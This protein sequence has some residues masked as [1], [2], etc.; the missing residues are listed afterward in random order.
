[1]LARPSKK[2]EITISRVT[3]LPQSLM[4]DCYYVIAQSLSVAAD[5]F[6][7]RAQREVNH[8]NHI[9]FVAATPIMVVGVIKGMVFNMPDATYAKIDCFGVDKRYRKRGIGK[10]LLDAYEKYV[11][12][13]RGASCVGLQSSHSA[14]HFYRN[15]GYAGTVYLKKTFSR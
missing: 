8:D 1:M 9:L 11:V 6:Y 3:N 4:K 13:E 14:V 5:E 10:Q 15:N 12:T 7:Y 2:E